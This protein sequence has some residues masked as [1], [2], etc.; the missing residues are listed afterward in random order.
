MA[1]FKFFLEFDGRK[2]LSNPYEIPA[3]SIWSNSF[4]GAANTFASKHKLKTLSQDVL[5]AGGYR[6]FFESRSLFKGSKQLIYYVKSE[7]GQA[8]TARHRYKG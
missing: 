5:D 7:E 1:V 3:D 8:E 6:V 2:S 4:I